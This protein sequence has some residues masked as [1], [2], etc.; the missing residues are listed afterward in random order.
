MK[1]FLLINLSL[2]FL[3]QLSL[4]DGM[5]CTKNS[6]IA[7][8]ARCAGIGIVSGGTVAAMQGANIY[9]MKKYSKEKLKADAIERQNSQRVFSNLKGTV[10]PKNV[11]LENVIKSFKPGDKITITYKDRWPNKGLGSKVFGPDQA[12]EY[13]NTITGSF[14]YRGRVNEFIQGTQAGKGEILAIDRVPAAKVARVFH[15]TDAKSA[16]AWAA[17]SSLLIIE[18]GTGVV[19]HGIEHISYT[20]DAKPYSG[21]Q[22]AH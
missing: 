17:G 2:L 9:D 15:P 16:A 19:A 14:N 6:K 5:I 10:S 4:A 3:A 18:M 11:H 13:F 22:G 12:D 8:G 1:K 21:A 7:N 20:P